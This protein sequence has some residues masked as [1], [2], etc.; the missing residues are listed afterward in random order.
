MQPT[1]GGDE[2]P[3]VVFHCAAINHSGMAPA[4]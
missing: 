2:P 1:E 3:S 4:L